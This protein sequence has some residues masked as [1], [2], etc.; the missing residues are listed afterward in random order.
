MDTTT[1]RGICGACVVIL[2]LIIVLIAIGCQQLGANEVGLDYSGVTLTIDTSQLY[3]SG[4]HFLGPNHKFLVYRKDVQEIDM[5]DTNN[6]IART[7]DGLQVQLDSR[8]FFRLSITKENLASLYL[9][10]GDDFLTPYQ[11]IARSVIRDVAANFTAFEFWTYRDLIQ[12][13]MESALR[14]KLDDFYCALEQFLL[15]NFELPVAFQEAITQTE[16]AKQIISSYD[17]WTISNRTQIDA[18][19]QQFRDHTAPVR[20]QQANTTA[21]A[22][23]LGVDADIQTLKLTVDAEV[24]GYHIIQEKLGLSKEELVAYVWIDQMFK[25][26]LAKKIFSVATPPLLSI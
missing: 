19:V 6:L 16:V 17:S 13:T 2:I 15:S 26:Q 11:D 20:I 18:A 4:L 3:D 25:D 5:R 12:S 22:F 21:Q 8:I 1:K 24:T 23:L 7:V 10:F 14:L 9:M